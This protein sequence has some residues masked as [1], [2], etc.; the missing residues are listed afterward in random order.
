MELKL[1]L[2][3]WKSF[4]S[5]AVV[6]S[7]KDFQRLVYDNYSK[8]DR[9]E[10]EFKGILSNL[11]TIAQILNKCPPLKRDKIK[12]LL[13]AGTQG[14]IF[15]LESGRIL[16]LFMAGY[17]GGRKGE[18]EL[19]YAK[20]SEEELF[21]GAGSLETFPVLDSGNFEIDVPL[22][23]GRDQKETVHYV[24]MAK[25]ITLAEYFAKEETYRM[26][27]GSINE[28][29]VGEVLDYL[30]DA[31]IYEIN[32]ADIEEE[33]QRYTQMKRAWYKAEPTEEEIKDRL[34]EFVEISNDR[35]KNNMETAVYKADSY[36][37]QDY[38]IKNLVK[39]IR[40]VKNKH[41][42]KFLGD[43]HSGNVGVL[44]NTVR[45]KDPKFILFDA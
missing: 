4:I 35:A 37:F 5:E 31:I 17:I 25:L 8:M 28:Y 19:A 26:V 44:P 10:T 16:K 40:M 2:E 1:I 7:P 45:T 15:E 11:A 22:I 39:M 18:D 14:V 30:K 43:L 9:I 3:N 23:A 27:S 32:K 33:K 29:D 12:T 6:F 20:S 36:G 42:K 34:A 24:V 13:A 38:E 21:G 41:G